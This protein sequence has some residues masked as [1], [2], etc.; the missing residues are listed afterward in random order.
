MLL[1]Y[2]SVNIFGKANTFITIFKFIV[3]ALVIIFLLMHLDV[4]NFSVG[5][6]E[7]GGIHGI[8]SAVAAGGIVFTFQGFRQPIE[9][10]GE[11][12]RPQRDV[13]LAII[14]AVFVGLVIYLLLQFAFVGAAPGGMLQS[15]GWASIEFDSPFAG[16]VATLGL[17]WLVNLILIDAVI[18]PTGTGNI[19]FSA[20]ARSIYAWSKNGFFYSLFHKI[21]P[22]TG[23]P[24]PALI[25]TFILSILWMLPAKFQVWEGLVTASTSATVLTY[26]VGPVSIM[27]LRKTNPDL[28]RPFKLRWIHLIS[29]LAFIAATLVIYWSGWDVVSMLV[30]VLFA[31]LVLYFAFAD[32]RIS[33]QQLKMDIRSSLWLFGY[34]IFVAVMSLLG[35]FGPLKIIAAP[36]DTILTSLGILI[37]YY[38]G[39]ATALPEARITD[40]DE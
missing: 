19:Y 37:F 31:S 33:R 12:R 10:A 7:P 18:S 3:P 39:V 2:W 26:C 35:S 17:G 36:W 28:N 13:P 29:P 24:R 23:V 30:G 20:N 34:Y 1:N 5:G 38:W 11:S 27:S 16:L 32:K 40:D 8:F 22:K 14:L 15:G 9:F 4:S 6:A 25:L 21:N